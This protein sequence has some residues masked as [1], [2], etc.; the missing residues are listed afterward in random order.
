MTTLSIIVPI[1]N[2]DAY[3]KECLLSVQAALHPDID[4]EVICVNDG[5]NDGSEAIAQSFAQE[6]PRFQLITQINGGY[7]K[8]INTGMK[9]ASG[10]F[11]TIV[12]SDD[13]ISENA[14]P[15][16]LKVLQRDQNLDFVKTPYQPFTVDGPCPQIAIPPD[17]RRATDILSQPIETFPN[18]TFTSDNLILEPPAIW[19]G[20]YRRSTLTKYG[21][22]L[23]E[24]PGAGY[25][26]TC[27]SAMCFLNGMTYQWVT[28][29]YYL[30][31][32]DRET[33]SR[34]VCNRRSEIITLF[35]FIRQNL[36]QNRNL[37]EKAKPYFYAVYF[38]RLI[39]F[40]QRVRHE[41]RFKLFLEAFRDFTELWENPLLFEETSRLLP[42][43]EALKLQ[44]FHYGRHPRL[45]HT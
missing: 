37:T 23:P 34:H 10:T 14:Y 3:L 5:S 27:F 44:E 38:R 36:E 43:G 9:A 17:N 15:N 11:F 32:I 1:Y 42:S 30:Y 33:A 22:C 24:T 45:Y 21:I 28:D 18:S 25:Q 40:M 6:D 31:R 16:L 41:H 29:C 13:L 35:R 7:G 8:A 19:S 20:V 26:D 39:W 2:V 4:A 12:E